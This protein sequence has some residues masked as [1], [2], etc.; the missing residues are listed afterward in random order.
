[1]LHWSTLAIE[2]KKLLQLIV[3]QM[4]L[5]GSYL[6]GGTA[7]A[8]ILGHRESIDFDWF[9][10]SSFDSEGLARQL[11]NMK[12]FEVNEASKGTLH[13]ILDNVRVTWLYYPNPLLDHLITPSEMPNLKLASLKDIGVMKLAA[14]SHRGSAKDFID[15]YRI[16]QEGLELEHL[17]KLMP[18]K[19]P[20]AKIN[21]YHI[22]KSFSYFDDAEQEPL[23]KM[24][25]PLNWEEMK[26]F[27]LE[28]QTR[29]LKNIEQF[30]G[31]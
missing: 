14:L 25:V 27:F 21:Y 23:P 30:D 4:P 2:Q 1:V 26:H 5:A 31:E 7:L 17:I 8:L 3:E 29:L 20:E 24:L 28:E 19:F 22:V 18:A 10:P 13:G 16:R 11:S 15:L 6:A 12:S 9:S